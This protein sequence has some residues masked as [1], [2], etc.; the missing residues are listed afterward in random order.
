MDSSQSLV[1]AIE[2]VYFNRGEKP[3]FTGLSLSIKRGSITAIMG[4][5]GTG[6]TTL[7]NL[8]SGELKPQSGKITVNDVN[9]SKLRKKK[10]YQL[11]RKMGMLFQEGGLFTDLNVFD[12][13][14][15]PLRQ[16]TSLN[17]TMI[18]DL[19]LMMLQAV[20]LRGA[21]QLRID[22]LSGGMARRVALARAVVLGP[23]MMLYDEPFAGQDPIGRGVLLR[24]IKKMNAAL[25]LTSVVVSHDVSEATEI[26]DYI[27]ILSGGVVLSSGV[28]QNIVDDTTPAVE[29][30]IKGL[31][32]GPV[33][34]QYP[35]KP[36][37]EDLAIE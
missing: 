3:I 31:P 37:A 18:R 10:L 11:R 15:F 14:A 24:L 6:K 30:F 32:D 2:D 21:A 16:H 25:G 34:Y 4:P 22:Q 1:V 9:V 23:E 19:V 29:Q 12:N 17:E 20:G 35:A 28:P 7:L 13:V 33:P 27:Y 8:I 36:Y 26:A 5:S